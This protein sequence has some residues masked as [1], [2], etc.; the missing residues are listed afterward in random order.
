MAL[1]IDLG[2]LYGKQTQRAL[3]VFNQ[4]KNKQTNKQKKHYTD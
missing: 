2:C 1:F 3:N 4:K